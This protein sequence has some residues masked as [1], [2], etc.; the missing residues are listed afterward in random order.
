MPDGTVTTSGLNLRKNVRPGK[1]LKVLRR[2]SRVEILG[3]GTW[4]RV[5][6]RDGQEGFVSGDFIDI[7]AP[8]TASIAAAHTPSD[9]C[10]L[11][12]F[13]HKRFT[14][15]VVT[16]D[17]EFFGLLKRIAGFAEQC[18]LFVHVTSSTR[19]HGH[20]VGSAIVKPAERSNHFIGHA[21][22]MN[23]ESEGGGFFNSKKLKKLASQPR[24]V[25][26]FIK[27]I[28]DDPDLRWGGDFSTPDVVH[29]DDAFN[30][31]HPDIYDAKFR[32][33]G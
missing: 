1:V 22:D 28:R 20:V 4:L 18:R 30:I 23:L 7:D 32:S 11:E 19:D 2:S 25:R 27:L 17:L 12:R 24:D 3:Q 26:R 14:G 31:R 10:V 9:K 16:A 8:L 6:T 33:R 5:R 21:I 15:R 29:I 13:G